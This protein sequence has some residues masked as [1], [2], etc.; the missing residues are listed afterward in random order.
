MPWRKVSH[1]EAED[2]SDVQYMRMIAHLRGRLLAKEPNR[3]VVETAGVGYDI[4]I[5]IPTF[6]GLPA[7]GGEVTLHI[8]THVREDA[9]AL[10]G[11]LRLD[12]KRLFERLLAVSGIG[13][14]LAITILSGMSS[15]HLVAAIRANDVM[16]LTKV[17]GI[18]KKT[19]ERMVVELRDKLES[20][21]AAPARAPRSP[22]EEDVLSAL[23]NL[24]YARPAAEKAAAQ[25]S[26]N[27]NA[28]SFDKWFREALLLLRR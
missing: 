10:F 14:K 15:E 6:T 18:G 1:N 11:F 9:L 13:P 7:P 20:F 4:A 26:A 19:A 22:V 28:D 8:H 16:A 12:E 27:G 23:V 2:L 3:V 21:A 24:G 17:P 25:A 5:S